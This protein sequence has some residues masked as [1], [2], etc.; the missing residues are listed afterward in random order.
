MYYRD[1]KALHVH[2]CVLVTESSLVTGYMFS[3]VQKNGNCF[4]YSKIMRNMVPLYSFQGLKEDRDS[5]D[6]CP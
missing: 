4:C 3:E 6:I 5:D 2:L 1:V